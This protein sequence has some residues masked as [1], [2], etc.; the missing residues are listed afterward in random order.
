MGQK[1]GETAVLYTATPLNL[2]GELNN[3]LNNE[4]LVKKKRKRK[5]NHPEARHGKLL[6]QMCWKNKDLIILT[7]AKL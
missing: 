2:T 3:I 6:K 4:Y 5:G 7:R 1:N